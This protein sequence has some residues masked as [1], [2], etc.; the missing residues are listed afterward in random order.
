MKLN[1]SLAIEMDLKTNNYGSIMLLQSREAAFNDIARGAPVK[2]RIN[3]PTQSILPAVKSILLN[4]QIICSSLITP[5]PTTTIINW[6]HTWY[7]Q[8]PGRIVPHINGV[9]MYET[10][11]RQIYKL[12]SKPVQSVLD[13]PI[14]LR[15]DTG[16]TSTSR[17]LRSTVAPPSS[18]NLECGK[19]TLYFQNHLSL[20]GD[21]VSEGQFPW[22]VPLFD[23]ERPRSPRYI[24]GS[25]IIT[26]GHLLTAAHCVHELDEPIPAD[27]LLAIPG[28]YNIDN[29]LDKN[30]VLADVAE[31][32]PHEDYIFDDDL[33]DA[34]IAVLR[35][36]KVLDFSDHIVPICLWPG[37]NN[38]RKIVGSEG[39]VA[40]WGDTEDGASQVPTYIHTAIVNREQCNRNWDRQ[41]RASTR[42]FCGDGQGAVPC[43][44]DSGSGLVLKRGTQYYLRGVVSRGRTDPNTLKC[45]A[46]KYVIYTDVAPFRFW[47][48]TVAR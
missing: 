17:F 5:T 11:A 43:N 16:S 45:D 6:E 3:F 35:L 41:Y 47:L 24:C 40:G 18:T 30:A 25:T 33:N 21:L 29:F 20:K 8:L 38:L 31:V 28:M 4:G 44:G 34:D 13:D 36:Q 37:D 2:Y 19:P 14:A 39:Y 15:I 23:R 7:G 42:V 32:I 27:R 46:S 12:E 48:R 26:K 10:I 9:Q 1:V 22:I